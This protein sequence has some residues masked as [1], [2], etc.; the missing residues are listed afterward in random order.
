PS[1][2]WSWNAGVEMGSHSFRNIVPTVSAVASRFFIDTD[3]LA[4]WLG[5]ERSLVR[6]PEHRF[7]VDATA[8][9]RAGRNFAVT[10]GGFGTMRGALL[11][12]WLPQTTG[13]DYEMRTSVR[14]GGFAG[15]ATVDELYQLGVERDNDLWLRGHTGTSAGRKGE[16]PLGRRYFLANWEM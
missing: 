2:R 11:A 8:E 9:A 5:G 16:A 3:S 13:D 6:L 1:G 10:L 12:K 15:H 4:V 14:V 7:T